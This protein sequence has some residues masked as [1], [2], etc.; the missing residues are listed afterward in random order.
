MS[1]RAGHVLINSR[2]PCP[3]SDNR[4]YVRF[5]LENPAEM[6]ITP[7]APDN[8]IV[9]RLVAFASVQTDSERVNSAH[10]NRLATTRRTIEFQSSPEKNSA[11]PLPMPTTTFDDDGDDEDW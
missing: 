8:R 11:A 7:P 9:C 3:T 2:H 4:S 1:K 10:Q 5:G 6:S